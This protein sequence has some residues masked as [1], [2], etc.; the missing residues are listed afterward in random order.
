MCSSIE[1]LKK[2]N[3]NTYGINKQLNAK[4]CVRMPHVRNGMHYERKKNVPKKV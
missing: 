4:C 1:F 3:N 2:K